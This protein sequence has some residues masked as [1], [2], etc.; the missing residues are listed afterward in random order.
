VIIR[1][2][3][4]LLDLTRTIAIKSTSLGT[5]RTTSTL[6]IGPARVARLLR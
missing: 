1:G 4:A 5:R 3:R 6:V 2:P